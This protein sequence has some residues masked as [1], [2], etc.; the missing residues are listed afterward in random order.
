[1]PYDLTLYFRQPGIELLCFPGFGSKNAFTGIPITL[2]HV[3]FE[4]DLFPASIDRDPG[5]NREFTFGIDFVITQNET[6]SKRAV[7]VVH[8]TSFLTLS[9]VLRHLVEPEK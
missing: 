2:V 9:I 4:G 8:T 6:H 1:M 5:V 3:L 7:A